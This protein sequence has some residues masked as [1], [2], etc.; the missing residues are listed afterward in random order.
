LDDLNFTKAVFGVILI[1]CFLF[2]SNET[3]LVLLAFLGL[4]CYRRR[5]PTWNSAETDLRV[6]A[7]HY[8][9]YWDDKTLPN[10]QFN[11][12]MIWPGV[13]IPRVLCCLLVKTQNNLFVFLHLIPKFSFS[14]IQFSFRIRSEI[15]FLRNLFSGNS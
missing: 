3:F 15:E 8:G 11:D 6:L 4:V 5:H 9:S 10:Y 1:T 14:S 13:K 7:A 2:V 12:R